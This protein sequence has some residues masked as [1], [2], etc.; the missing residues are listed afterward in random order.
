MY[1]KSLD[2]I[3]DFLKSFEKFKEFQNELKTT[4]LMID[5][6]IKLN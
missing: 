2:N 6:T 1:K 4:Q 5:F 3:G